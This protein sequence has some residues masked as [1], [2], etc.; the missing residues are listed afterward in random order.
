MLLAKLKTP[1]MA[2]VLVALFIGLGG[3]V[4]KG[5]HEAAAAPVPKVEKDEGLIWVFD[6]PAG[7]LIAHTPDGKEV[8]TVKLRDGAEASL[9]SRAM[10]YAAVTKDNPLLLRLYTENIGGSLLKR[11]NV[12]TALG[13]PAVGLTGGLVVSYRLSDPQLGE[14]KF[15]GV[16]VCRTALTDMRSIHAGRARASACGPSIG[17]AAPAA[18]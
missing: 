8:K 11:A 1:G 15:A 13:A 16:L 9:L 18:R 7:V 3:F 6:P 17:G 14:V 10:R 5:G 4:P 2:G 12:W